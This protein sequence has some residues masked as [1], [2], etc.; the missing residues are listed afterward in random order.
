MR[1]QHRSQDLDRAGCDR[2][3]SCKLSDRGKQSGGGKLDFPVR[4]CIL[5]YFHISL[6]TWHKH[7]CKAHGIHTKIT[8]ESA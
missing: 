3:R 8:S 6:F 1:P 5:A 4:L 7:L 2:V